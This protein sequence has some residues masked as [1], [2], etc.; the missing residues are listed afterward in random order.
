MG[1]IVGMILA[2]VLGLGALSGLLLY[3][4]VRRKST[5]MAL[6]KQ[7]EDLRSTYFNATEISEKG[8]ALAQ[9]AGRPK[10]FYGRRYELSSQSAQELPTGNVI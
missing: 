10:K 4:V 6:E 8:N 3:I 5:R 7:E 9:S 2:A 1:M